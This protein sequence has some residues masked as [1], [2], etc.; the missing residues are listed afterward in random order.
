MQATLASADHAA[1]IA[2]SQRENERL[3]KWNDILKNYPAPWRAGV[4]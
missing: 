1:E 3:R 2:R 4:G